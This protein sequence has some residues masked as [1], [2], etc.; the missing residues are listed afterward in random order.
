M[1]Q[2]STPPRATNAGSTCADE[3][4]V[5]AGDTLQA[6]ADQLDL[7]IED[8]Q[9]AT[10]VASAQ[11]QLVPGRVLCLPVKL[12]RSYLVL[13]TVHRYSPSNDE[14]AIGF[15]ARG[16]YIG[17][18]SSLPLQ[19][20]RPMEAFTQTIDLNDEIKTRLPLLAGVRRADSDLYTL[21]TIGDSTIL[22]SL[23]LSDTV[24]LSPPRLPGDCPPT[25]PTPLETLG[26]PTTTLNVSVTVLLESETGLSYP[27]FVTGVEAL[28]D[29][30]QFNTCYVGG[31]KQIGFMLFP[32]S[33]AQGGEYQLW[34]RLTGTTFGP[35]VG[36]TTSPVIACDPDRAGF[37][38][39][40][41]P[42]MAADN[43]A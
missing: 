19:A 31:N 11:G 27:F 25:S 30:Q 33:A 42:S 26:D 1:S 39:F 7:P 13:Q 15:V 5:Q 3:Y 35:H 6:I 2:A 10:S 16:G 23:R 9:N 41:G 4:E 37:I 21:V 29:M 8:L 32:A 18:R 20:I 40:C 12:V 24:T 14:K 17:L 22:T 36:A 38:A 43:V 28:S 34:M